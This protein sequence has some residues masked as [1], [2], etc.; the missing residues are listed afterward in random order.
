MRIAVGG[1]LHET[2]TFA[3]G[4]TELAAF[5]TPGAFPGLLKGSEVLTTLRGS[6]MCVG[7]YIDAAERL[8]MELVPLIWTFAMPSGTV[9][10]SA[11]EHLRSLLL[12]DLRMAL[13]VEGVLLDLH[14]AMVTDVCDDVEGDL[15]RHVRQMVGARVP[16]MATLDFHAN[17]TPAMA[18]WADALIGYDTYPHVDYFERGQEAAQWMSAAVSGQLKPVIGFRAIDMLI[19]LPKQCTLSG[20]MAEAF[21]RVHEIERRPGILGITLA[22]GFPFADIHDAGA[23]VAVMTNGDL[24]L[25]CRTAE[26]IALYLWERR[27]DFRVTLT[28]VSEAIAYARKA[29]HGPVVLADVSD[30]PGGGSPCD[31]TI[32]L[33]ELV[34]A[35]VPSAVVAVI[36]DPEAVRA[37]QQAGIGHT[38]T[39]V[40]GGKTDR[41]HGDPLTLTGEIRW[42]GEKE[43]VNKG[44]MMTGM[45]VKMGLTAV[46]VVNNVEIILTEKHFQPFDAEALRCL[47]IEPRDRLLIGLKSSVHFRADYQDLATK[48]FEVDTPG[49][50]SPDLM[51][52]TYRH[53]RRPIYPLDA[54]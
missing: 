46:F 24:N 18:H 35:G 48:I 22:G 45:T 13:P 23:S 54:M 29:G 2:N 14:G 28:P 20:P 34:E 16:V 53:V 15:L 51:Q 40:V 11:Y 21:A 25:A 50:T 1:I 42:V 26:E 9:R 47:N 43:Y 8:N 38:A 12:E 27:A 4:L 6:R 19:G 44:A 7:G 36:V 37:A 10:H 49:I 32:M 33:K 5:E 52:Y 31:G 30:N 41:R 3:D 17:I 39:L